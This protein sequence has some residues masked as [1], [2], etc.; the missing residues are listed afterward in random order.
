MVAAILLAAAGTWVLVQYVSNADERAAEDQVLV[1]VLVVDEAIPQGTPVAE[2][3][4]SMSNKAVRDADRVPSA[5][6]SLDSV[7][8]LVTAVDL[9]PGEQ[10]SASRF[11][12]EEALIADQVTVD[13]P[14]GLLELTIQL[15]TERSVGGNLRP[16]DQVAVLSSF[17]PFTLDA[18]EPSAEDDLNQFLNSEEN[19]ETITL[20]TPNTTGITAHKAL[21]TRVQFAEAPPESR[22]SQSTGVDVAP[23]DSFF[24]TLAVPPGDAEQIVFTAEFG[25]IW[26]A[27]ESATTPEADPVLIITRANVYR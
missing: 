18:V 10:V 1:E 22:T 3:E 19:V 5:L 16:G 21:V 2:A 25:S 26:L 8:G 14:D 17:N 12:A 9:L 20:K 7:R 13:V 11:I 24:V 15:T 6:A 27:R 4:N 23:A